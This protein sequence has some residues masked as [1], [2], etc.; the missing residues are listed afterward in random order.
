MLK[1]LLRAAGALLLAAPAAL[2]LAAPASAA[3]P[4]PTAGIVTT[5]GG[6]AG[7]LL[8]SPGIRPGALHFQVNLTQAASAALGTSA[9]DGSAI[10]G[11]LG[12]QLCDPA[13]GAAV[14]FGAFYAGN[15]QWEFGYQAGILSGS[16]SDHDPC[17][18]GLLT[19]GTP[20]IAAWGTGVPVTEPTGAQVRLA[21]STRISAHATAA[22]PG[23]VVT[24][25]IYDE[26]TGLTDWTSQP[27]ALAA[28]PDGNWPQFHEAGFGVQ[29][30]ASAQALTTLVALAPFSYCMAG[31]YAG[32]W[33]YLD[34]RWAATEVVTTTDGT[35]TGTPLVSPE[36]SLSGGHFGIWSAAPV[37]GGS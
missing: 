36:E 6:E 37:V 25:S 22:G 23:R 32:Q 7:Y 33:R 13:T 29:A 11:A 1:H 27:L 28:T 34:G 14:Q 9:A 4:A 21:I 35:A 16:P 8:H 10:A 30:T 24:F 31:D 2:A 20:V 18:G 19:S 12:A 17:V 15:G 3:Q 5:T 26:S